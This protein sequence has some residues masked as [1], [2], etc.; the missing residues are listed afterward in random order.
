MCWVPPLLGLLLTYCRIFSAIP[1]GPPP[2]APLESCKLSAMSLN[3]SALN[4]FLSPRFLQTLSG[5]PSNQW[6]HGP[7]LGVFSP[8]RHIPRPAAAPSSPNA[9]FRPFRPV[10]VFLVES[11]PP[12]CRLPTHLLTK[13]MSP[14]STA[15]VSP[16]FPHSCLEHVVQFLFSTVPWHPSLFPSEEMIATT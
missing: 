4:D 10:A 14:P 8:P 5:D 1:F 9:T 2:F 12:M 6:L 3:I 16:A 13:L 15:A 7:P 11:F